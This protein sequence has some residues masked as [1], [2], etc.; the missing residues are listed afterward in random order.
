MFNNQ[1]QIRAN[2]P[3]NT[4]DELDVYSIYLCLGF[5]CQL[6][7]KQSRKLYCLRYVAS[8]GHV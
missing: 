4:P 1:I 6:R 2:L 3:E 7:I 5:Q 8:S